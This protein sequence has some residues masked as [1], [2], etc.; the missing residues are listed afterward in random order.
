M[1]EWTMKKTMLALALFSPLAISA[2]ELSYNYLELGYSRFDSRPRAD[3]YG[4]NGS[5]ALGDRFHLF[6]G[7]SD[8]DADRIT[9]DDTLES[10]KP[11]VDLWHLGFGYNHGLSASTDL[12]ARAAYQRAR[13]T[14]F[15]SD[16]GGFAEVGVRS[17]MAPSFEGYAFAGYEDMAGVSGD[18]YARLG[19]QYRFTER[20]GLNADLKFGNG[21]RLWFIGPR[22]T[23]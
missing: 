23:F 21:D 6:G 22:L 18:A 13:T 16:D 19:A 15:G 9:R 10:L 17:L 12:I 2:Q 1:M 20:W 14:G 5:V 8:L 7:F 3:G 4:L 11:D